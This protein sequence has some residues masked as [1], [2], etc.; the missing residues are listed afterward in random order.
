MKFK[1]NKLRSIIREYLHISFSKDTSDKEKEGLLL[2]L[3]KILGLE[4]DTTHKNNR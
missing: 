1:K 4:D 2:D 3:L